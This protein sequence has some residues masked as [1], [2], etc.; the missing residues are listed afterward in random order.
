MAGPRGAPAHSMHPF[1]SPPCRKAS[2]VMTAVPILQ[3][4][5]PTLKEIR[6]FTQVLRL[7]LTIPMEPAS[8]ADVTL[9]P[10]SLTGRNRT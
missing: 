3:R 10:H 9:F 1:T 7:Y 2:R 6:Q 5:E 8:S 4:R